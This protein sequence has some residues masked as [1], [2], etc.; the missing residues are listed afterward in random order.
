MIRLLTR[1]AD[2]LARP[3]VVSVAAALAGAGVVILQGAV[4]RA[5][6]DLQR[7]DEQLG[8]RSGELSDTLLMLTLARD[9][10]KSGD[11]ERVEQALAA[12]VERGVYPG[13]DD[14]DPLARA[15]ELG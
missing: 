13:A 1:V 8:A 5:K 10:G 15:G 12:A 11:P 7:L 4:D 9:A 14:V 2:L 3:A 6:A